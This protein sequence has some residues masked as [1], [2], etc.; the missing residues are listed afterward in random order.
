MKKSCLIILFFS[1]LLIF[2]SSS[3]ANFSVK[4]RELSI[5]MKDD[6]IFGN[7]SK[8]V[9]VTNNIEESI[10]ISWYLDNPSQDLIRENKTLIPSL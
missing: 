10:N 6:L 2:T 9:F 8:M 5:I 7:A 1:I 3:S 4:P